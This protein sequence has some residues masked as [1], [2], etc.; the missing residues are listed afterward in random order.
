MTVDTAL[1]TMDDRDA[2]TPLLLAHRGIV[3]KVAASYARH[4]DD[5]AELA[6]EITAQLWRAFPGYDRTRP[7]STWMYRVALN[8]AMASLR[9]R[10]TRERYIEAADIA[11]TETAAD[12]ADPE[13]SLLLAQVMASLDGP[14]RALLLLHL[15]ARSTAEMAD[16]LGVG[17][18]V[19]T[20]RLTR[21]RQ[22]LRD[23]FA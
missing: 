9:D 6:Q 12:G 17:P 3:H 2:F 5:R 10:R 22:R 8:T 18:S 16:I 15:E 4:P 19:I 23:R 21:I 11:E 7:F 14:S 13:S 1:P 20:T